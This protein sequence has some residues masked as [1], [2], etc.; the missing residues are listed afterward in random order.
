MWLLQNNYDII[1]SILY[2]Y[3][4]TLKHTGRWHCKSTWCEKWCTCHSTSL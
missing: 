3:V 1:L 4:T 2:L